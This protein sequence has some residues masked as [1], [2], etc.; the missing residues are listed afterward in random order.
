MASG[1]ADMSKMATFNSLFEMPYL[2]FAVDM[3]RQTAAFNSLFEMQSSDEEYGGNCGMLL[4][5]LYLR[6]PLSSRPCSR[7]C[8]LLSF[9]S[10]F[11]MPRRGAARRRDR[12]PSFNSLFEMPRGAVKDYEEAL[13]EASLS[14]LYLRCPGQ[15]EGGLRL[16]LA[17]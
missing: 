8:C 3:M 17:F 13:V 15:A 7:P 11:E 1:V 2:V 5:I 4:S 6:C 10:L 9:N 14:I 12:L 16:D